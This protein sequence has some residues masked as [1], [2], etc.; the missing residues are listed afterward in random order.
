MQTLRMRGVC[1]CVCPLLRG[2][3]PGAARSGAVH[4]V[5]ALIASLAIK[6]VPFLNLL[7][8]PLMGLTSDPLPGVRAAATAAFA[9]AVSLLPLA[10]VIVFSQHGNVLLTVAGHVVSSCRPQCMGCADDVCPVLFKPNRYCK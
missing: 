8:V 3:A 1:R 5:G 9:D 7:V 6:L 2:D 10:Q 4:M